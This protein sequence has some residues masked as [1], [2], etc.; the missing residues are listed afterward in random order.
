MAHRDLLIE[1]RNRF[2]KGLKIN[3]ATGRDAMIRPVLMTANASA[4]TR[5]EREDLA[6]API[7][8]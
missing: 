2:R 3:A 7:G 8:C 6:L 5:A 1:M 4:M